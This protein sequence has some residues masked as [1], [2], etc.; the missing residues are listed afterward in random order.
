M[1]CLADDSGL[2]VTALNGAP[3]IY[4]AR[5][6]GENKDFTVAMKRIWDEIGNNTDKSAAFVAVLALVMPDE[7][8]FIARGEV[9]GRLCYPPR[10]TEGFGYD[11]VFMPEHEVQTFSEMGKAGK[12]RHSHRVRAF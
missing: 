10:G 7:R 8:E 5:W 3:G 1:P 12:E 4:S 2:T 6:A 11:P 9:N